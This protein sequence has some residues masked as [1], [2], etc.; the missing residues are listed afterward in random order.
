MVPL[1]P[2]GGNPQGKMRWHES[3]V[4]VLARLGPHRTRT[5]PLVTRR[6]QRRLGAVLGDSERRTL[7]LWLEALRQGI[8]SAPQGVWLRDGGGEDCGASLRSGA[9]AM[10]QASWTFTTRCSSGGSVQPLGSMGAPRRRVAGSGGHD[11]A[12]AMRCLTESW[13]TVAR[14]MSYNPIDQCSSRHGVEP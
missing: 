1:R 6:L 5:G 11:T 12:C 7:R 8:R 2:E 13:P 14:F 10:P 9:R 3:E 4:G